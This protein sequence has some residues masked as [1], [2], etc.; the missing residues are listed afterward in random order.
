M[1]N[2]FLL[3]VCTA[4]MASCTH[5]NGGEDAAVEPPERFVAEV[6]LRTTPVKNQ[7][8]SNLCWVYA[9]LATI[10]TEHIMQGDSID[11]SPAYLAWH[12]LAGEA[13]RRYTN[14]HAHP[15]AMR[16][17]MPMTLQL[18]E[19]HGAMPF[20]SFRPREEV[21]YRGLLLQ[22]QRVADQC[23]AR[24]SGFMSLDE[25]VGNTLDSALGE[26]PSWVFML[27]CQYTPRE[28]AHSICGRREYMALTSFSHH[29]FWQ[30]FVLEVPDN[31]GRD[32]F[33]N[34]P[35]DTL[36]ARIERSLRSGHPVCWE[37][38]IT[39]PGFS[40]HRGVARLEAGHAPV[41]QQSRQRDF[42]SGGTTDDH[43]MAM[44]GIAHDKAGRRFYICKISWGR[45][46]YG[47]YVFVDEDYVRAKTIAVMMPAQQQ[48]PLHTTAVT[49]Q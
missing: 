10:E 42:E 36:M 5:K 9:M 3:L 46:V 18:L 39:E 29:P 34:V 40:H 19:E 12:M 6:L 27:G 44:V 25:A 26:P 4:L 37:G 20:T 38:D 48:P 24:R 22:L 15:L 23:R 41:T 32:M 43:C 30:P 8:S 13:H 1:R 33:L 14:G 21:D 45:N 47:G 16:G 31:Y 17:M 49:L 28:F 11:L 2:F 7:G 35:L